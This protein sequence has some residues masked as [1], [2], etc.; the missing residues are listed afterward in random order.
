[1]N[2][3]FSGFVYGGLDIYISSNCILVNNTFTNTGVEITGYTAPGW[4]HTFS[5]NIVNGK[6]LG[7]FHGENDLVINQ[8]YTVK[9]F[10]QNVLT[11]M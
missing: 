9:S 2:S 7:Y 3:N 10:L 5:N 4:Q 11:A 1:M 8:K 6:P